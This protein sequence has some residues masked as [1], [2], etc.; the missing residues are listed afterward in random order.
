MMNVEEFVAAFNE[1]VA[2]K[3]KPKN[4]KK[5]FPT[6]TDFIHAIKKFEG[7]TCIKFTNGK[8]EMIVRP[9]KADIMTELARPTN[10]KQTTFFKIL[11]DWN[12]GYLVIEPFI[13]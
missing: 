4:E 13:E 3:D 12:E 2:T 6:N 8:I 5:K 1:A 7:N 11:E 9:H 10:S